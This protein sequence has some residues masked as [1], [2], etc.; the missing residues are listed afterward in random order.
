MNTD[1][2]SKQNKFSSF[3]NKAKPYIMVI[4]GTIIYCFGISW[5]LQL[6]NI[7]SSGV[8]GTS[9]LI[10]G[11]LGK[12]FPQIQNADQYT[13]ILI[14]LINIPLIAFGWRGV[15]KKFAILTIVSI[16][17][18]TILVT[19]LD[20][21]TISPLVYLLGNGTS[22][23]KEGMTFVYGVSNG[24]DGILDVISS[25]KI[26]VS[27]PKYLTFVKEGFFLSVSAGEK[28]LISFVGGLVTGY[29]LAIALK[30]GGSTG[31]M[32]VIANY[33]AK[34]KRVNFTRLSTMVDGTIIAL[35]ALLS[36]QGMLLAVIRIVVSVKTIDQIYASYKITK[37]EV[38]T[39][40]AE[41]IKEEIIRKF[42]HSVTY[43]DAIGGYTKN[44][45]Q[46]MFACVSKYEV[47][48]YVSI[49]KRIDPDAFIVTT[50]VKVLK[51]KF[52]QRSM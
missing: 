8:T 21:Y 46:V 38:V 5:M 20:K 6:I 25:M 10:V 15:S 29:G 43:F 35:S 37:L 27:D 40:K 7:V 31:G 48:E 50:K 23:Y 18:Q 22:Y 4:F 44:Q 14:F 11:V 17:V 9:Q 45:K 30:F 51:S 16:I 19:I 12:Y 49:I 28:I 26:F 24:A 2:V 42:T 39:T 1:V 41:E 32:D 47:E 52:I 33:F 13:G 36:V 34:A 3:M